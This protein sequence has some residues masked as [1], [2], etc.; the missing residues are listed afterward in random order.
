MNF[1]F[2][3]KILFGDSFSGKTY[4]FKKINIKK[5]DVDYFLLYK[6]IK[7]INEFFF[8]FFEKKIYLL[9]KNINLFIFM[10]GGNVQ[11]KIKN[12]LIYKNI[13]IIE[14]KKRQIKDNFNRPSLKNNIFLKIRF[15]IRK[16]NYIKISTYYLFKC[17]KCNL[18][19]L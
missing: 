15:C 13:T 9:F 1:Y 10:G 17:Y 5:I 8:R 7:F 16:K 18:L 2:K 6:K 3:N 19:S 12:F 14:Q 11:F 4:Y